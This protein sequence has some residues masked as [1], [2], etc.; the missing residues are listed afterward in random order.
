MADKKHDAADERAGAAAPGPV[1]PG[2]TRKAE[3]S[4]PAAAKYVVLH[5]Q[6][7]HKFYQGDVVAPD[8]FGQK[9]EV[10]RLLDLGAIRPAEEAEAGERKVTLQAAAPTHPTFEQAMADQRTEI[11]KLQAQLLEAQ[12]KANAMQAQELTRQAAVPPGGLTPELIRQKDQAFQQLQARNEA[13]TRQLRDAG[14]QPDTPEAVVAGD[15]EQ[16]KGAAPKSPPQAPRSGDAGH[17]RK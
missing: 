7:G 9:G 3:S 11:G 13:L 2:A 1:T 17:T 16:L 14:L 12:Q 8:Q 10:D 4:D 6:V 5:G 15:D